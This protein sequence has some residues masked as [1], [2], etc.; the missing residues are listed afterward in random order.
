MPINR[1]MCFPMV[2]AGVSAVEGG[3]TLFGSGFH[4]LSPEIL[5]YV[6]GRHTVAQ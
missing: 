3:H 5:M 1:A 2:R 6:A 4:L